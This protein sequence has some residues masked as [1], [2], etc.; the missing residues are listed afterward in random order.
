MRNNVQIKRQIG[1][2]LFTQQLYLAEDQNEDTAADGDFE[3]V[4][5]VTIL[6]TPIVERKSLFQVHSYV[7]QLSRKF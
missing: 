7:Q 5:D 3:S 4:S 1:S 2:F 6:K